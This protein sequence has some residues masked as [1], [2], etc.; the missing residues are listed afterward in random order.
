MTRKPSK[1]LRNA[2]D[3][4]RFEH[5]LNK[6]SPGIDSDPYNPA[7]RV[8]KNFLSSGKPIFSS[9]FCYVRGQV[10]DADTSIRWIGAAV[11][12]YGKRI[13]FFPGFSK[14][15]VGLVSQFPTQR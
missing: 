10:E 3:T 5:K 9:A 4:V 2:E 6:G 1:P 15:H 11:R 8:F 14:E 13:V 12:T 7:S